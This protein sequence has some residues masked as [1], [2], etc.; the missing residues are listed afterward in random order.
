MRHAQ[1]WVKVNATVDAGIVEV[2]DAL[3]GVPG[4]RTIDSCEGDV[5]GRW[6]HVYFEFGDWRELGAFVFEQ[7]K[8]AVLQ[9]SSDASLAVETFGDHVMGK[10][11]IRAEAVAVVASALKQ[12]LHER[13]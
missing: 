1:V 9:A 8:P 4:L 11:R 13:P 7:L 5:G 10:L 6:A 2:V 12:L 3:N